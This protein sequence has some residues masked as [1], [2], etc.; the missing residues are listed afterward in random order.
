MIKK[1]LFLERNR[2]LI[3]SPKIPY[4]LVAERS[5]ANQNSLTFHFWCPQE[6]SNPYYEIRNLASY[7][8]NDEG[9]NSIF[10][11]T[12]SLGDGE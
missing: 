7:P 12:T 3:F 6:D 1:F 8:L 4:N 5:E 9:V 2:Q 10:I 11:Y